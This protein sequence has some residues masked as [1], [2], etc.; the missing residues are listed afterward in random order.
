MRAIWLAPFLAFALC[1]C[2]LIPM[3][4]YHNTVYFDIVPNAPDI[5]RDAKFST[6]SVTSSMPFSDRMLFRVGGEKMEFDEYH[7]WVANP[8][9]LV[10]R[11]IESSCYVNQNAPAVQI[12]IL[13][14]ELNK[15]E[16]TATCEIQV[17]LTET[18]RNSLR[19]FRTSATIKAK[20]DTSADF[21]DAMREAV[22]QVVAKLS[23]ELTPGK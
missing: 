23:V 21:A 18:E 14:F 15:P 7:R 1:G 22:A 20:G 3:E 9:T 12:K 13:R 19:A 16:L 17:I 2:S 6:L 8:E 10:K 11:Y 5:H 4:P